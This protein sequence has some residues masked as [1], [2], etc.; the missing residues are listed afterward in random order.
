M[1]SVVHENK[2]LIDVGIQLRLSF[3]TWC[4]EL[5]SRIGQV[6]LSHVQRRIVMR[7]VCAPPRD[8]T[9]FDPVEE[10]AGTPAFLHVVQRT[11]KRKQRGF[12]VVPPP[13]AKRMKMN[14]NAPK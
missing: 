5:A 7:Y 11:K 8:M 4:A 2:R 3:E 12:E 10:L 13:S 6:S 1:D 9:G 14:K